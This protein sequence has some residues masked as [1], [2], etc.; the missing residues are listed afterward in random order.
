M[1]KIKKKLRQLLYAYGTRFN[2]CEIIIN[3]N[4]LQKLCY[5][6]DF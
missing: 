4:K 1:H 3:Y 6:L 2:I 5:N